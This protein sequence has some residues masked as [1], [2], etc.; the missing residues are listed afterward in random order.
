MA[1]RT[2]R[3]E[4]LLAMING[5]PVDYVVMDYVIDNGMVTIWRGVTDELVKEMDKKIPRIKPSGAPSMNKSMEMMPSTKTEKKRSLKNAREA[6]K[7]AEKARKAGKPEKPEVPS[8]DAPRAPVTNSIP[9]EGGTANPIIPP[10]ATR[11]DE[12]TLPRP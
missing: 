1:T 2:R 11:V 4:F 3:G 9:V 10:K 7:A 8:L 5:R 6:E 12:P